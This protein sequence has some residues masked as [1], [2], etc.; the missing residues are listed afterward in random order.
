MPQAWRI[1]KQKHAATAFSGE[2]A[3]RTGGRWNSRGSR[4]VYASGTQSLAILETLV[5]LNPLVLFRYVVFRIEFDSRLVE[6]LNRAQ[7]PAN[8][9]AQPPPASTK[10]IGDEWLREAR[11]ALLAVPTIIVPGEFNYLI[12]PLHRDFKRITIG[13]PASFAF[14]TRLFL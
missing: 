9:R 7:L 3:A 14:D 6:K 5:H 11:S 2:G 10:A 1:V 13:K 8:W 4:V 12:N